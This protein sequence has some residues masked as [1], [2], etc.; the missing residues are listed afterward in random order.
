[1]RGCLGKEIL[2]GKSE[3]FLIFLL[4]GVLARYVSGPIILIVKIL[5]VYHNQSLGPRRTN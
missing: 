3:L 1:V 4:F 5:T 2:A